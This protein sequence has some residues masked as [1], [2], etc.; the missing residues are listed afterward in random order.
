MVK[1][2][3]FTQCVLYH[4]PCAVPWEVVEKVKYRLDFPGRY[5]LVG[6]GNTHI[7]TLL[8]YKGRVRMHQERCRVLQEQGKG[9]NWK[10]ST[11][12]IIFHSKM[13]LARNQDL[14]D[15]ILRKMK[16]GMGCLP[17]FTYWILSVKFHLFKLYLPW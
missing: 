8:W 2:A 3:T 10:H 11:K 17:N 7:Q 14:I 16:R 12:K 9:S 13:N 4:R 15:D 5:N 6:M 1:L